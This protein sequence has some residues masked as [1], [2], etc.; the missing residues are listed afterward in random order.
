MKYLLG[1]HGKPSFK[2]TN[3]QHAEGENMISMSSL[4]AVCENCETIYGVLWRE[5]GSDEYTQRHSKT[6]MIW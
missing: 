2:T 3:A 6:W 1:I 5:G 4:A